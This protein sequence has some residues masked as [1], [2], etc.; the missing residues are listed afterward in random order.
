M[1]RCTQPWDAGRDL[2]RLIPAKMASI[3][4]PHGADVRQYWDLA[5]DAVLRSLVGCAI[6]DAISANAACRPAFVRPLAGDL[7]GNMR[8]RVPRRPSAGTVSL[9]RQRYLGAAQELPTAACALIEQRAAS[10]DRRFTSHRR[11]TCRFATRRRLAS[12]RP[13][14]GALRDHVS[15]EVLLSCSIAVT[16]PFSRGRGF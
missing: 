9:A 2:L 6:F 13:T 5:G 10:S 8:H 16:R 7:Q 3:Y 11:A 12:L 4:P 14:R 1:R 15:D